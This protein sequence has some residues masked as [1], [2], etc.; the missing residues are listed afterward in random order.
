VF[1]SVD[2]QDMTL[3]QLAQMLGPCTG[4]GMRIEIVPDDELHLRPKR[5]VCVPKK[6]QRSFIRRRA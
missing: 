5:R 4:W 2:G 3:L 1:I 6:N